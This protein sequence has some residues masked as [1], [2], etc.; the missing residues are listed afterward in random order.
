MQIFYA[1]SA[2]CSSENSRSEVDSSEAVKSAKR[3][4]GSRRK[5]MKERVIRGLMWGGE[6]V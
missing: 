4:G 1:Q 5:R 6:C 3:N 2:Q